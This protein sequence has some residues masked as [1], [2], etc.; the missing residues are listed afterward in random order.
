MNDI[1]H[2]DDFR[3]IYNKEIS[4]WD[5]LWYCGAALS[6]MGEEDMAFEQYLTCAMPNCMHGRA[7][8]NVS[9]FRPAAQQTTYILVY[10]P[11]TT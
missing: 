6:W 1:T 2:I 3:S 4:L 8:A 10:P 5:N 7:I 11:C 9:K